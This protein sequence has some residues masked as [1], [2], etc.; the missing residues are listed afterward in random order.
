M[1]A[2]FGL[3][4]EYD[5]E[6]LGRFQADMSEVKTININPSIAFKVNDRAFIRFWRCLLCGQ[7]QHLPVR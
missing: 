2:P 1:N 6:W 5:K 4:T 7:R 3:K